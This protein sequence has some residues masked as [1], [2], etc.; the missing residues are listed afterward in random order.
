MNKVVL[1]ETLW[2]AVLRSAKAV[3][4]FLF[5]AGSIITTALASSPTHSLT[6][7]QIGIALG[8]GLVG[9]QAV[10]HAPFLAPSRPVD[11]TP[12]GTPVALSAD[13]IVAK[14]LEPKPVPFVT[15]P[16]STVPPVGNPT[17]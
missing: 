17:V 4:A 7:Y 5:V 11:P 16:A 2:G 8:V 6:L 9:H 3:I 14:P 15:A 13:V 10:Y 12:S 1:S